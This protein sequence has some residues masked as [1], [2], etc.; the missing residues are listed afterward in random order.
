MILTALRDMT[1]SKEWLRALLRS[2]HQSCCARGT[3]KGLR[4]YRI[5]GVFRGK[6]SA[7]A[8]AAKHPLYD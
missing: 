5:S 7:S 6:R 3:F 1:G 8:E 2:P 4:L